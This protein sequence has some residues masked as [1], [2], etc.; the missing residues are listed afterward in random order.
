MN[1]WQV[2]NRVCFTICIVC[3]VAGAALSLTMIWHEFESDFLMK[4]WSSMGVLFF[5]SVATLIVS[6]F[7]GG[8]AEAPAR[9]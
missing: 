3:I 5:S 9:S 4:S 2:L 8:R 1:N 6:R 7:V